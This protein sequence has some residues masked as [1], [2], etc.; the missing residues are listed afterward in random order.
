MN[1]R[2]LILLLVGVA[3]L[4]AGAGYVLAAC[5]TEGLR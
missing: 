4:F 1:R 2:L 3:A 5:D